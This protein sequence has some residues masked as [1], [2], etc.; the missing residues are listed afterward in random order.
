MTEVPRPVPPSVP[1]AHV[2]QTHHISRLIDQARQLALEANNTQAGEAIATPPSSRRPSS[3][4]RVPVDHAL[5]RAANL[6]RHA[7]EELEDER[8]ACL[9]WA[10]P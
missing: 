9:G 10:Q 8:L 7:A 1:P 3:A 2:V 4:Q 6:L 5:G